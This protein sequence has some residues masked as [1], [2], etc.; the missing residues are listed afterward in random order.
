[1][2]FHVFQVVVFVS[3]IQLETTVIAVP[4]DTMEM[5]YSR[6]Q[7]TA[8]LVLAQGMELACNFLMKQLYA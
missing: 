2:L 7:M 3:T 6:L 8:S 5:L 4:R 1:M